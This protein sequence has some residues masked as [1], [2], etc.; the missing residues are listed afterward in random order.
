MEELIPS[1]GEISRNL[2]IAAISYGIVVLWNRYKSRIFNFRPPGWLSAALLVYLFI[3]VGL[4]G[5]GYYQ[6]HKPLEII[7]N[8]IFDHQTIVVDGKS[9]RNCTFLSC[10]LKINGVRTFNMSGS[11]LVNSQFSLDGRARIGEGILLS[12]KE[13]ASLEPSVIAYLE[14]LKTK[15]INHSLPPTVLEDL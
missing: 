2:I 1:I 7:Q 13:S 10:L 4:F 6:K 8:Q 11:S 15:R 9:F 3:T 14:E 12:M 5:W